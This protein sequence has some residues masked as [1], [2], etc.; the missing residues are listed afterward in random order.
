MWVTFRAHVL[1]RQWHLLDRTLRLVLGSYQTN[2]GPT[3]APVGPSLCK[4]LSVFTSLVRSVISCFLMEDERIHFKPTLERESRLQ[5]LGIHN[6]TPAMRFQPVVPHA[7][8]EAIAKVVLSLLGQ[9]TV[10]RS[11]LHS[12]GRLALHLKRAKFKPAPKWHK[13]LRCVPTDF[14]GGTRHLDRPQTE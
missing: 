5:M 4:R 3:K 10:L 14:H 13:W 12:E 8:G 11:T 2:A 6:H 9:F 1:D 7:T